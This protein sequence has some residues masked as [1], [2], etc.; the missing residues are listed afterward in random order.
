MAR[1][2][3]GEGVTEAGTSPVSGVE[4]DDEGAETEPGS[5][6]QADMRLRMIN[7]Y[8][9]MRIFMIIHLSTV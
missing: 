1:V 7:P 3:V 8:S 4:V 5:F 2:G 9:R 6:V